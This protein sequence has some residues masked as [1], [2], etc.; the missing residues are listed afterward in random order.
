MLYHYP[1]CSKIK[2]YCLCSPLFAFIISS[3][4]PFQTAELLPKMYRPSC[5]PWHSCSYKT[6]QAKRYS[7]VFIFWSETCFSSCLRSFTSAPYL[8][9]VPL[10]AKIKWECIL[11][12][13]VNLLI[14][15]DIVWY[16]RTTC[17]VETEGKKKYY[18][19]KILWTKSI[20]RYQLT[21]WPKRKNQSCFKYCTWALLKVCVCMRKV[22]NDH[23]T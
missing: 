3:C 5:Q 4:S 19:E 7:L 2:F 9:V 11:L 15:L 13:T 1:Q 10:S 12:S 6:I 21:R 16:G 17:M 14:G 18:T 23:S 8:P 20:I 22:E